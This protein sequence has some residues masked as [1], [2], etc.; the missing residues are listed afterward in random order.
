MRLRLRIQ[1]NELPAVN[2][3]WPLTDVQ[4]KHTIAQLLEAIN[5]AFPLEAD[6]WG[7]EDYVVTVASYECLHYH[8]IGAVCKDEDEVVVRPL[9]YAEVR[10]RTLM[11]RSQISGDGRKLEDGIAFG[12]PLLRAPVRPEVKIPARKRKRGCEDD[13]DGDKRVR[14]I[15]NGGQVPEEAPG[16]H[17]T[18]VVVSGRDDEDEEDD[19]EEDDEDFEAED[20]ASSSE[21]ESQS[22]ESSE[23]SSSS[24]DSDSSESTAS[25]DS[26][27]SSSESSSDESSEG[28]VKA[29]R[30]RRGKPISSQKAPNVTPSIVPAKSVASTTNK[31]QQTKSDGPQQRALPNEGKKK[32]Q[33][34]NA[35]R[36]DSKKLAYLKEN[37]ILPPSADLITLRAWEQS[38]DWPAATP[39]LTKHMNA[40]ETSSSTLA[41]GESNSTEDLNEE[42]DLAARRQQLLNSIALGGVEIGVSGKAIQGEDEEEGP[43]VQSNKTAA[44]NA[45][46]TEHLYRQNIDSMAN[47]EA[48][49]QAAS[50]RRGLDMNSA[51]RLLYGSLG[52]R[53][54]KTQE[55]KDALQKRLADRQ[56]TAAPKSKS[57]SQSKQP[58]V[59]TEEVEEDDDAWM[60]RIDLRAVECCDEGVEL[61]TPPFPFYQRWDPQYR[62]KKNRNLATYANPPRNKRRRGNQ[63]NIIGEFVES[64][65]KYNQDGYGDALDYDGDGGDDADLDQDDLAEQ[66]L[67]NEVNAEAL[68]DDF[69][70]LPEDIATLATLASEDAQSGDYVTYTE[71]VCSPATNWQPSMLT[72]TVQLVEKDADGWKVKLAARDL[73]PK[74]Y[75][76]DGNRVYGKFEMA[77]MSE[78]EEDAEGED[79]RIKVMAFAELADARLLKREAEVMTVTG[80]EADAE[81]Q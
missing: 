60:Q 9:T 5:Q 53:T 74:E 67:L 51:Q 26:S 57:K 27:D 37:N 33:E 35:R 78:D 56:G 21:A 38:A 30:S 58:G 50:S 6:K 71:L 18:V 24:S 23:A 77:E 36:R 4:Q 73:P 49:S 40:T 11:G 12:R 81:A 52:V 70:P 17:K 59:V 47:E 34:R 7:L 41:G 13:D 2:T 55:Q 42:M 66:Q 79:E 80:A 45:A 25:S 75:D 14:F 68:V 22:S 44:K 19:D 8:E 15:T 54:P 28:S 20:D 64:Y 48:A 16:S 39:G 69:P 65:D 63:G 61:S 62:K 32:T 29:S 10:A 43:E 31:T 3:L 46:L 1:R 76:E 72:R